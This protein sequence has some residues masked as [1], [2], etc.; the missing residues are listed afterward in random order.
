MKSTSE[1]WTPAEWDMRL[2]HFDALF[3]GGED[4]IGRKLVRRLTSQVVRCEQDQGSRS[5]GLGDAILRISQE[6]RQ[7]PGDLLII[8]DTQPQ[9]HDHPS[10]HHA[11]KAGRVVGGEMIGY[12]EI[13][14]DDLSVLN[15]QIQ[16]LQDAGFDTSL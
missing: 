12:G 1:I 3:S 4:A 5:A 9:P 10:L 6:P 13:A 15:D 14:P 7:T 11:I 8:A 16:E 2:E